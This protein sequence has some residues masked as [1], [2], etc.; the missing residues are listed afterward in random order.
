LA[1]NYLAVTANNQ[2]RGRYVGP[3]VANQLVH[4]GILYVQLE[5]LNLVA[6]FALE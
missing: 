1:P 4:N 5:K 3:V 2:E 6:D